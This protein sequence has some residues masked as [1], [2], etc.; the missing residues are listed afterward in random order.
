MVGRRMATVSGCDWIV[1]PNLHDERLRENEIRGGI[2]NYFR[3]VWY[4]L[5][6]DDTI[7]SM[8][9]AQNY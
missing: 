7:R 3:D 8:N 9:N 5:S 6:G 4:F 2:M 1:L